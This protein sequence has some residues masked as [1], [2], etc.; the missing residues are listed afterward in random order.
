MLLD[1]IFITS[2]SL[3]SQQFSRE[4]AVFATRVLEALLINNWFS[5]KTVALKLSNKLS[6]SE[7]MLPYLYSSVLFWLLWVSLTPSLLSW[8]TFTLLQSTK[9]SRPSWIFCGRE[10]VENEEAQRLS[11]ISKCHPPTHI[12]K[13]FVTKEKNSKSDFEL[14]LLNP[15]YSIEHPIY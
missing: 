14:Q 6:S 4:K 12:T 5:Q 10:L 2:Y 15:A 8:C 1:T 3:F 13:G 9:V 7:N 11:K